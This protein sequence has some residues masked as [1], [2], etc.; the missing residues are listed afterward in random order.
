M[1]QTLLYGWRVV[2]RHKVAS[3]SYVNIENSQI[4]S[5]GE[6]FTSKYHTKQL[7][8]IHGQILQPVVR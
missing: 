6:I 7:N 2:G 1:P 3:K 8:P 4:A 5:V